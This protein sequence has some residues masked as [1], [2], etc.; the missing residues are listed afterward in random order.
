M[1]TTRMWM[2]TFTGARCNKS[3]DNFQSNF[4]KENLIHGYIK[5]KNSFSVTNEHYVVYLDPYLFIKSVCLRSTCFLSSDCSD[6]LS[7]SVSLTWPFHNKQENVTKQ[8]TSRIICIFEHYP[9]TFH[10]S[11]EI[12]QTWKCFLN[13]RGNNWQ[14]TSWLSR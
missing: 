2:P 10:P 3:K 1:G 12:F 14:N 6:L 9:W 5:K 13:H 4:K 11:H 8:H 7:I